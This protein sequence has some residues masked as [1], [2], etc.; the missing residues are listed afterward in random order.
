MVTQGVLS[1]PEAARYLS[2]SRS[3]MNSLLA[4]G[5]IPYTRVGADRRVPKA[6]LDAYLARNLVVAG[7]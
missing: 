4:H 7:K 1:I 5:E 2:V 6:A 3:K